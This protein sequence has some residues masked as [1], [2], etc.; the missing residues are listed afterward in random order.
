MALSAPNRGDMYKPYENPHATFWNGVQ[1]FA[2]LMWALTVRSIREESGGPALGMLKGIGM[3]LAFCLL[4]Y[5]IMTF[6]GLTSLAVR[7]NLMI[8]II[9]GIGFFFA[10][11]MTMTGALSAMTAS[12]EMAAHPHLSPVLFVYAKSLAVFYNYFVAI[13]ILFLGNGLINGSFELQT[14]ILFFPLFTLGWLCGMG[15][16]MV[17]GFMVFYFSWAAMFKRI[18]MKMMF[19]T[20]GKFMNANV[21]PNEALPFFSWNPLFHLIDQM[22]GAAFVNYTPLKTNMVYPIIVTFF[23]LVAGHILHDYMLRHR[24]VMT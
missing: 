6:M 11:K 8:F 4:F 16:G 9:I 5:F 23:L 10:A 22:R 21:I 20:S 14:P 15:A 19:L 12:W 13:V 24:N 18:F 17:L 2:F 1:N 3:A 7:G